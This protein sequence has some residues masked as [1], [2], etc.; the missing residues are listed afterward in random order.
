MSNKELDIVL[1]TFRPL[2]P[3]ED[4][5]PADLPD[6]DRQRWSDLTD[7]QKIDEAV[8][9]MR[10]Y[11]VRNGAAR[12]SLLWEEAIS[13]TKTTK[14]MINYIGRYMVQAK[15]ETWCW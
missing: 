9:Y 15:S 8:Q 12:A 5:H 4:V 2:D 10:E 3:R 1:H 6:D 11:T 7:E 13:Q 14:G